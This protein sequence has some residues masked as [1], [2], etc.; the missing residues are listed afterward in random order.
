MLATVSLEGAS[1]AA[2]KIQ[3]MFEQPAIVH[4]TP[5]EIEVAIG[6]AL[7]PDHGHTPAILLQH[8]DIAMQLAK[9]DKRRF[10]VYNPL[11]DPSPLKRLR[12]FGELRQAINEM[13]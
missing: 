3:K 6:I 5:L 8:A 2:E 1:L 10:G 11:D 9:N 13:R 4:D 12:L 7:Y